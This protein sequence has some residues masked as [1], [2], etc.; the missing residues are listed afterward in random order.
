MPFYGQIPNKSIS[1]QFLD[2]AEIWRI[3][4]KKGKKRDS[5]TKAVY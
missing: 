5:K 2:K 1:K 3:S 4:N